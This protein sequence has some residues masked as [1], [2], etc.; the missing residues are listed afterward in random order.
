MTACVLVSKPCSPSRPLPSAGGHQPH[1]AL[2]LP[3]RAAYPPK[4]PS[5]RFIP[6]PYITS[7]LPSVALHKQASSAPFPLVPLRCN[8][9]AALSSTFQRLCKA[10]TLDICLQC[11]VHGYALLKNTTIQKSELIRKI[12]LGVTSHIPNRFFPSRFWQVHSRPWIFLN[13]WS[14]CWIRGRDWPLVETPAHADLGQ[15]VDKTQLACSGLGNTF[16]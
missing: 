6:T 16:V 14:L 10:S 15:P 13:V 12:D 1:G 5:I 3:Q 9:P 2:P 4:W 8:A 11:N 7:P